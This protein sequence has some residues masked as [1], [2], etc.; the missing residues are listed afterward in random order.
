MNRSSSRG[1]LIETAF[2][3]STRSSTEDLD[4]VDRLANHPVLRSSSGCSG[5]L[6][7]S[8]S[9][10]GSRIRSGGIAS[11]SWTFCPSR[12]SNSP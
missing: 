2:V 3:S 12:E 1:R 8:R 6:R 4:E 7:K 11:T 9:E 5:V 10:M